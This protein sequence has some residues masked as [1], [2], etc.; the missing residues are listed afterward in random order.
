MANLTNSAKLI[1]EMN[2]KAY[3]NSLC[4]VATSGKYCDLTGQ[5]TIPT[6]N[7]STITIQKN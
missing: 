7:N 2:K 4:A 3:S 5:P 6:V 1:E